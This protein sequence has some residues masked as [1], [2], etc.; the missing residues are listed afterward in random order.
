VARDEGTKVDNMDHRFALVD[1]D[2]V[3]RYPYR[4]KKQDGQFGF[5]LGRDRDGKG[6][7]VQTLEEVIRG[8]VFDGK[9]VRTSDFPPSTGKG[10]SGLSL[11]A[12]RE[13][14]GYRIDP[15]LRHLVAGAFDQPLGAPTGAFFAARATTPAAPFAPVA[16]TATSALLADPLQQLDALSVEAYS[17]A[18][19][20]AEPAM[21]PSQREM[22]RGHANAPAQE[23]SMQ[24]IAE[25]GGYS[26]YKTANVQYGRLGRMFAEA[27]GVDP[28][29]LANKVQAICF[30]AGRSDDAGHFV[31]RLRPQLAEALYQAGWGEP[32]P[33]TSDDPA[34]AGAAAELARDEKCQGLPETTRRALINARIGQGGYRQRMLKVWQGRCAV[35]GLGIQEALTASHAMAWKDCDNME[36]LDEYNGLL[37]SATVDRLFDRG[38]ISFSDTGRLLVRGGLDMDEL[39]AA[40][41]TTS[42]CLRYVPERCLPYWAAHRRRFAF[43]A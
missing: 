11:S 34:A 19:R 32:D 36:R 1:S 12:H 5:V 30:A 4:M 6:E 18:L 35:T 25:H 29:R 7:V 2:G 37:L 22:L 9:R 17:M 21:T 27:L 10:S 31:C 42:S 38:L 40:G 43:E 13:V 24:R 33:A 20:I 8:V 3:E 28:E 23:M 15:S 16:P 39:R 14:R 41:L 26:D